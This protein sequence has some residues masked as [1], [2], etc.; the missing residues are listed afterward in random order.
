MSLSFRFVTLISLGYAWE[1]CYWLII[2]KD[3]T[4]TAAAIICAYKTKGQ[5]ASGRNRMAG[6]VVAVCLLLLATSAF[7]GGLSQDE[8]YT[9]RSDLPSCGCMN[10]I[11]NIM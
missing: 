4:K 11:P 10:T 8:Q 2:Y 1:A 7:R 6:S 9:T 3:C 5:T